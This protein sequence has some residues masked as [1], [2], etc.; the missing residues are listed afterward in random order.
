MLNPEQARSA[1]AERSLGRGIQ[2]LRE[3]SIDRAL[4]ELNE[5]ASLDPA[6]ARAHLLLGWAQRLNGSLYQIHQSQA[7]FQEAL[8]L[9]PASI[10]ARLHLALLHI[11]SV[12][13]IRSV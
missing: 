3:G 4:L 13:S 10:W 1:A 5:A 2:L 7:A 11:E 8:R 9:D 6:S 12:V